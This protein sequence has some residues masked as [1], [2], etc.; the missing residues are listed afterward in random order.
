MLGTQ[1]HSYEINTRLTGVE[2]ITNIAMEKNKPAAQAAD[3]DP[4]PMKLHQ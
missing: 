2:N 4:F 3:A 1:I